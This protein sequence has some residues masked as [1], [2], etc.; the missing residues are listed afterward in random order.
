MSAIWRDEQ[1]RIRVLRPLK[2]YDPL[3]YGRCFWNKNNP[4]SGVH[5]VFR[6][7][8]LILLAFFL[9]AQPVFCAEPIA[10]SGSKKTRPQ[11]RPLREGMAFT[12][13]GTVVR[14]ESRDRWLFVTDEQLT[15]TFAVVKKN[16]AL[17]LLPSSTLEQIVAY[18]GELDSTILKLRATVTQYDGKN[19]IFATSFIPMTQA[20]EPEKKTPAANKKKARKKPEPKPDG[21]ASILPD[22]VM[23]MLKPERTVNLAKRK[24]II[25]VEGD[26][27][28]VDRIGFVLLDGGQKDFSIDSVGLK[29]EDISYKLLPCQVLQRTETAI[30]NSPLRQRYR[31]A[32]ILTKYNNNYYLLLQR[33]VRSY[34]HQNFAR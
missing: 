23:E 15:D 3:A 25:A 14:G 26:K 19:F 17:E 33:S 7:T 1:M 16:T 18:I 30:T 28:L 13:E 2:N 6:G 21:P 11:P 34:N 31:I 10:G 24:E 12:A 4:G 22:D 32:G 27:M 20:S 29:A 8:F 9:T 5:P